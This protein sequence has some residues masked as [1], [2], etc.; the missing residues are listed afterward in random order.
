MV[1]SCLV[2]CAM[3]V[4]VDD[5]SGPKCVGEKDDSVGQVVPFKSR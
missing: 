4:W 5:Q 2:V 1:L 3:G